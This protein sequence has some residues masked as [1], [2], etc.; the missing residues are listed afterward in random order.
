MDREKEL[1][2]SIENVDNLVKIIEALTAEYYQ[3]AICRRNQM[4][5]VK[6][7]DR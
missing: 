1:E 5:V 4:Y 3:V 7:G 2:L 6:I